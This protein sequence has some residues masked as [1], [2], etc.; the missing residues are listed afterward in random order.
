MKRR[1][2]PILGG[3]SGF[4]LGIFVALDLALFGVRAP[5]NV[6]VIGLPI[7]GIALGVGLAR[8]APLG[9]KR[10]AAPPAGGSTP[11]A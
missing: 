11:A 5:D 7:V 9:R 6:S 8:W 2:R 4:F 3:I 10:A 1:G